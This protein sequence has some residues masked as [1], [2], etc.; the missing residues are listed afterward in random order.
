MKKLSATFKDQ[1]QSAL[2]RAVFWT[3]YVIRHKGAPHLKSA[4]T[5]LYW[6]Q[7]L[8]LDVLLVLATGALLVTMAAYFIIRQIFRTIANLTSKSNKKTKAD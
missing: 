5:D 1:P 7:Y 2:D 4:A 3:E 6:H 8:L